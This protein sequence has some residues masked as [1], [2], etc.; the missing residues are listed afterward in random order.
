MPGLGTAGPGGTLAQW[1]RN[2]LVIAC[3]II[4]LLLALGEAISPGFATPAQIVRQLTIA[5]MLGTVAAGQNMVILGGREGIDLSVGAMV[6]LGAVVAGNV[7]HGD[8]AMILPALLATV[9]A[10]SAIGLINGLGVTLFRI[11]PLVMTLGMLGVVQG[12]LVV[13]TKGVPSGDA[14]P[15]LIAL[16]TQP[17]LLGVPGVILLWA[18]VGAAMILVLRFTRYGHQVYAVGSNETAAA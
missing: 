6:S 3:L 11:P 9:A 18:L 10:T 15:G 7:M 5:A 13:I 16:M 8:N 1:L 12:G 17:V 4:V 14:A 2:P